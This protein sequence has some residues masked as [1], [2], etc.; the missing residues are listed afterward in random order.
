MN[1]R[2]PP[3]T[4]KTRLYD[5]IRRHG[6]NLKAIFHLPYI[7]PV[8][9]SKKILRLENEAHRASERYSSDSRYGGEAQW[10]KDSASV[11]SRLDKILNFRKLKIPVFV[12]GDPRGCAL[13]I[14]DSAAKH[15]TIERDMGGY[16]LL[17]P[18]FRE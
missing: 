7:D 15:M 16:G 2:K 4:K 5:K 9:L 17:A 11:L 18:D 6:E 3:N 14:D 8:A 12:N 1:S 13:K 10:E